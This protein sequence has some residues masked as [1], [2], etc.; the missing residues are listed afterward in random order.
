M[1]IAGVILAGGASSRMGRDKAGAMLHGRTMLAHVVASLEPQV[2]KL[3]INSN[4]DAGAFAQFGHPVLPDCVPGRVGPLA[5]ILTGLRWA[6]GCRPQATHLL[7]VPCDS[8][9]LPHDIGARLAQRLIETGA[10]IAVARDASGLQPT[11]GLWPVHLSD[12]LAIDLTGRGIRG[13][14]AW[15]GSYAVAEIHCP[16]LHNINTPGDL[17]AA[18]RN[19]LTKEIIPCATP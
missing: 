12:Q 11:I 9:G 13:M 3:L 8:P 18:H 7:S 1:R 5:G 2:E 19:P 6:K 14:Q 16:V 4:A 10:D 17:S 15:L